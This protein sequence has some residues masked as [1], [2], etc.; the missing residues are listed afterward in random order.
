MHSFKDTADPPCTWTV[1]VNVSAIKRVRGLLKVD[2]LALVKDGFKPLGE[3]LAD[4]IR[5]V[6]VL[7]VL[8]MQEAADRF[9][10]DEQFGRLMAG[11]VLEQATQSFIAELCD[12]FPD[13]KV[14]ASLRQLMEKGKKIEEM[15]ATRLAMAVTNIDPETIF[16]AMLKQN[17]GAG[18][19]AP[20]TP[21]TSVTS[22]PESAAPTPAA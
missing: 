4:P 9:V 15:A 6:D 20:P 2:L 13:A 8:C 22:S 14:R 21:S 1:E 10:T 18:D 17:A 11:D 12:F 7:Y 3:L 19:A 5:L 16:Q